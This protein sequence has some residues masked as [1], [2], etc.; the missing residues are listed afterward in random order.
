MLISITKELS[1]TKTAECN[2]MIMSNI[3]SMMN[4]KAAMQ[5]LRKI[6]ELFLS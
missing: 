5:V 2:E 3:K 6:Q 1:G 4:M